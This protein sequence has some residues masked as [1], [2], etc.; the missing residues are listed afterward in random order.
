MD[1]SKHAFLA[2]ATASHKSTDSLVYFT[3]LPLSYS[4]RI[5][6]DSRHPVQIAVTHIPQTP[7]LSLH[8]PPFPTTTG[9][10]ST[11]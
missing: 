5:H 3:P 1:D 8:A 4:Q 10:R 11:K 2:R 6:D 7:N 9:A